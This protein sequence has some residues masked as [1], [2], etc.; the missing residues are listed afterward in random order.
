MRP[1]PAGPRDGREDAARR[2]PVF[3]AVRIGDQMD[4]PHH[5]QAQHV[6]RRARGGGRRRIVYVDP[7]EL[8]AVLIR[9]RAQH[10][11]LAADALRQARSGR[12]WQGRAGLESRKFEEVAAIQRQFAQVALGDEPAPVRCVRGNQRQS[13]D[14]LDRIAAGAQFQAHV[15]E[16]DLAAGQFDAGDR[17]GAEAFMLD[18]ERVIPR[19]QRCGDEPP[20]RIGDDA[21]NRASPDLGHPDF[22]TGDHPLLRVGD[23]TV[24][25]RVR[26]RAERQ[27]RQG[28]QRGRSAN[29]PPPW[30]PEWPV[31]PY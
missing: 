9:P 28:Q 1:Q 15:V 18:R 2:A 4:F 3:G 10:R 22:D 14:D 21:A 5:L 7:V 11:D 27:A 17:Q 26:L 8:E 30:A 16:T 19:R 29:R 23:R 24:Q 20:F 25:R 13:R 6:A 12:S 31:G